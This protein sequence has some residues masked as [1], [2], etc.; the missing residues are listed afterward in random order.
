[1]RR[2]RCKPSAA[3]GAGGGGEGAARMPAVCV[4]RAV[5]A[6]APRAARTRALALLTCP[7]CCP[8]GRDVTAGV[9]GRQPAQRVRRRWPACEAS[10]RAALEAAVRERALALR[11]RAPLR[12]DLRSSP[13][14]TLPRGRSAAERP[15]RPRSAAGLHR[16]ATS[17][18]CAR[19]PVPGSA[20]AWVA[21][22][23]MLVPARPLRLPPPRLRCSRSACRGTQPAGRSA[24]T[25]VGRWPPPADA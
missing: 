16:A 7:P 24:R 5:S 14:P 18:G 12:A 3:T 21:W 13:H 1:M 8:A 4:D 20:A 10:P 6:Y 17:A 22:A 23:R 11:V 2:A 19:E 25:A 15:T 9:R